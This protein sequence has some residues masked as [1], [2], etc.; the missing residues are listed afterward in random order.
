MPSLRAP[1]PLRN[2]KRGQEFDRQN[3][4]HHPGGRITSPERHGAV[5]PADTGQF[6]F[7]LGGFGFVA[8]PIVAG[9]MFG[10]PTGAANAAKAWF[11]RLGNAGDATLK[12]CMWSI[13]H[14]RV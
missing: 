9:W 5:Q 2:P 4:S 14:V 3:A 13:F 1:S 8:A 6:A 11:P 7:C 12:S 10:G